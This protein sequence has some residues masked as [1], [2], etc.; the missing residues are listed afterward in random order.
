MAA[1]VAEAGTR[2]EALR[3][4]IAML[5][6][7]ALIA[8]SFSLGGLAANE[9]A[10]QALIAARF[11]L[12]AI[13][14]GMI[15]PLM[16]VRNREILKTPWRYLVL[17]GLFAF[18]FVLMFEGLKTAT[19]V[20]IAAVFTL[21]PLITA[22]IA[23]LILRQITTPYMALALAIGGV[24]AI[25]VIFQA[26]LSAL[27]SF[28]VGRGEMVFFWG[29][30]AH[31]FYTPL[32]RLLN[33]GEHPVTMTLGTLIAGFL[34]LVVFG[35]SEIVATD[36]FNLPGVVWILIGYMAV[37]S[38]AVTL[39]LIQYAT[40]RLPSAKVMAY[41][42]LTPSWVILWEIALGHGAPAGLI[43]PGVVLT[44]VALWM[45]VRDK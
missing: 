33:R 18:Y 37:F 1:F 12:S 6:F 7:S 19:P 26:D 17:G 24:G 11:F 20:S 27:L 36:W 31:A 32:A 35:W 15:G 2:K 14:V 9:I 4:H 5:S 8:G 22:G 28:H 21:T 23:W 13:L 10:P 40:L 45:L 41:T 3:G 29:M 25:W 30:V 34:V 38:G 42:Y 39:M 16:G 44:V 43:L